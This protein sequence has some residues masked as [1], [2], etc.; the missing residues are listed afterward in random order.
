MAETENT[1]I[2]T[3]ERKY[4]KVGKVT[5]DLTSYS[6]KDFGCDGPFEDELLAI[7]KK[8]APVE[9]KNIIE[10]RLD[11]PTLYAL[12]DARENIVRWLPIKKNQ[13]VLEVGS[14]CGAVTGALAL[15]AGEVVSCEVSK[16]KSLINANRHIDAENL[17]IHVGNFLEVEKDLPTDFDYVI[18]VGEFEFAKN[19]FDSKTPYSDF[20]K[21][22]GKH[23]IQ[24]GRLILAL[25]NRMGLKYFAGCK[26]DN[27]KRYFAGIE[28]YKSTDI[29]KT[30]SKEGLIKLFEECEIKNYK[31][32]YPYPDYKFMNTLFS[33]ERLPMVGEL[34]DNKR[35]F[36]Q[37]RMELFSEKEAFDSIVEDGSFD[38]FSNSYLV[39][40]GPDLG[41]EYAKFSGDRAREYAIYTSVEKMKVGRRKVKL[42]K[43]TPLYPEGAAHILNM[44]KYYKELEKR[45][46]GS[47][48]KVNRCEVIGTSE[49]PV[50]CFEYLEG[51]P[52]SKMMDECLSKDDLEGFYK[53][54]DKYFELIGY[55][56]NY[57]IAD[58]DPVFSNIL[59]NEDEW[60]LIDYEWS[61]EAPVTAKE[62]A[63]RA[64]YCYLLEDINRNKINLDLIY[65][66]ISLPNET[67]EMLKEDEALFQKKVTGKYRSMQELRDM[68]GKKIVN[69][70]SLAEKFSNPVGIYQ[71]QIYP[72]ESDGSFSEETSYFYK[73]AYQSETMASV[74]VPVSSGDRVIRLDP[75][76][77]ACIV[78]IKEADIDGNPFPV[79]SKKFIYA[80]GRKI[81]KNT[82][83]FP[84]N[85]PNIIFNLE[86][87]VRSEESL[88]N[89]T[90]EIIRMPLET[91]TKVFENIKR[92]F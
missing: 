82:F 46:E 55:N 79:D 61:K 5:L 14:G 71:F 88:L 4:E 33:D 90:M 35:N 51:T 43:K 54:F 8:Y 89:V 17:T 47:G 87:L 92:V 72:G 12:S 67:A 41:V 36:D 25:E 66:K 16:K 39:V 7:S 1:E 11:W 6:G 85:D 75:L 21:I 74:S 9:F 77:E 24:D 15:L 40:I 28:G 19:Y 57:P 81:G 48:L 49:S 10:E 70:I 68:I 30:F 13:K 18:V 91:A 52:L 31:F 59:V 27:A 44:E 20:L 78:T 3:K 26:E 73:D 23:L 69:P 22:L 34:S 63:F 84:T 37:D 65:D 76:R 80:N 53:L 45:Y 29:A 56:E 83:V 2:T 32:Y 60:N 38:R 64:I 58:L 42:V 50:A 62:G 86:G